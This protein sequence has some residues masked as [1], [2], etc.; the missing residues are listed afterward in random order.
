MSGKYEKITA[1]L[2]LAAY[3]LMAG[4][5]QTTLLARLTVLGQTPDLTLVLAVL[6][7]YLFGEETGAA[8]GLA[9]GFVRD[10]LAGRAIGLGMLL[11]M[12]GAV[13]S[14]HLF[15][16][17]FRRNIF[18]GLAQVAIVTC[19][20]ELS[21]LALTWIVPTLPDAS[22]SLASLALRTARTLPGHLLAN[23]AAG[24]PLILLLHFAGPFRRSRRKDDPDGSIT[25]E[26][27]WRVN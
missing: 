14:A 20:Y 10:A 8:T 11:L 22:V 26:S 5:L 12:F 23:M 4:L 27:A 2:I 19:L 21:V 1:S 15:R 24:L 3:V 16:R 9:A 13:L 7:G 18:L 17:F 6:C 25:R